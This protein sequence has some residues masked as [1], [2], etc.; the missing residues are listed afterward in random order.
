MFRRV[1]R[2]DDDPR[3][4]QGL[5]RMTPSLDPFPVDPFPLELVPARDVSLSTFDAAAVNAQRAPLRADRS[6]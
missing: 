5:V 3:L 1:D 6:P 2:V 4:A